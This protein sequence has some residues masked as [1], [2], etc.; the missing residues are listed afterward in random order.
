M[1]D[2][3]ELKS[4]LFGAEKSTLD[5]ISERLGQL[6]LRAADV[7][8]VLPEAIR[9][10]HGKNKKLVAEL[11]DPV[12]ESVKQSFQEKP[13]EY[14]DVLYPVM[15][16]A[17]RKSIAQALKAFAQQ[18]NQTM[19]YSL[20]LKGVSWRFQA[21]RSG[22]PFSDFVMRETLQYRV[23]QAYLINRENGLL[24]AH[25]HREASS[26]KDGDAVS[27]MFTAIQDF[28]KDS[29]SR[30]PD[31]R[32]ET[33]DMGEFTLWA[34]HG[35]Q[36]VIV[37]VIRGVP[38][39]TVRTELNLVL[40][41]L[42][43]RYAE[44]LRDFYGNTSALPPEIELELHKV[45][46]LQASENSPGK[47]LVFWLCASVLLA[48]LVWQI[49]GYLYETRQREQQMAEFQTVLDQVPGIL[50][51]GIDYDN[52]KYHLAG[53]RDPLAKRVTEVAAEVGIQPEQIYQSL[54]PYQSLDS[55]MIRS[56][57]NKL[58]APPTTV[59]TKVENGELVVSGSATEAWHKKFITF[60]ES[61]SAGIPIEARDLTVVEALQDNAT[62]TQK[63]EVFID[64]D[65]KFFQIEF[66]F[67]EGT[68][69]KKADLREFESFA[70]NLKAELAQT[71]RSAENTIVTI[72]GLTDSL[73]TKEHNQTL[74][75]QRAIF[76]KDKLLNAGIAPSVLRVPESNTQYSEILNRSAIVTVERVR[77]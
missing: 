18:I 2:L 39:E 7:S 30:D 32:L 22:V 13:Q 15:G 11:K 8:D 19:E 27:A 72:Y 68:R 70:S 76:I 46:E 77:K 41:H 63:Q 5:S 31:S 34:L 33:A 40:E 69:L 53:L 38:P 10:S 4:L 55:E 35:P 54:R 65:S 47:P 9:L 37:C 52:G 73:G 12:A 29:F 67:S 24:I 66:S 16:P 1:S 56:R 17:I 25:A 26:I 49:G 62:P 61:G 42:H 64:Y 20:S 75:K 59:S 48:Y 6:E 36:A 71:S 23:E 74:A 14:V 51:T 45:L 3:E 57:F 60:A 21:W 58:L 44:V 43:L 50:I 28:V